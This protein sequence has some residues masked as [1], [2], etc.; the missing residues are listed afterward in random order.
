M[1]LAINK[2]LSSITM[3]VIKQIQSKNPSRK[4]HAKILEKEKE[5]E[6]QMVENRVQKLEYE[7]R[8]AQ[9]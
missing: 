3:G 8:R 1:Q 6:R 9:K 4:F 2:Q 5:M 7:N